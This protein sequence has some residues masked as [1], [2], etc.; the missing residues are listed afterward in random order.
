LYSGLLL[1]DSTGQR[2]VVAHRADGLFAARGHRVH[3]ELD[4][5]LRVAE[6]LLA[7]EQ[8]GEAGVFSGPAPSVDL[9]SS[10]SF[11]LVELDAIRSIHS[12]Y[13]AW[14]LASCA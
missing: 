4:V 6:R 7:I 13:G 9:D 10:R 11:D 3:H 14:L 2:R 8:G 1:V 5:F 12:R